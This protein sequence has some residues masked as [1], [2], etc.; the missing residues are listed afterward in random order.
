MTRRSGTWIAVALAAAL[1]GGTGAAAHPDEG[2]G[3]TLEEIVDI[4][5]A[6]GLGT[7]YEVERERKGY[8]VKVEDDQGVRLKLFVDAITGEVLHQ[9]RQDDDGDEGDD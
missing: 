2:G 6:K 5:N 1:A 9:K 8:E 7:V 4:V 3:L